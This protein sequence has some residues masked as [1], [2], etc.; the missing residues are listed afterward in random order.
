MRSDWLGLRRRV[1][2]AGPYNDRPV[3]HDHKRDQGSQL[4]SH[5]APDKL[6]RCATA[7][8]S[9][10]SADRGS[11]ARFWA[12]C[13]RFAIVRSTRTRRFAASTRRRPA[14]VPAAPNRKH[15]SVQ[16]C[17]AQVP[18]RQA[19][20]PRTRTWNRRFWRPC[21]FG[22]RDAGVQGFLARQLSGCD[23]FAI[24]SFCEFCEP[25][26]RGCV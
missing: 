4:E 12:P 7:C 2:V 21:S 16:G 22:P 15:P 26:A 1:P 8:T 10:N 6:A 23:R 13:D 24:G 5:S 20:Y 14:D 11:M 17:I 19:G 25:P 3:A 18:S 9:P